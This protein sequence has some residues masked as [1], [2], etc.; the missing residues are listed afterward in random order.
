G[1]GGGILLPRKARCWDLARPCGGAGPRL[2][3]GSGPA[4]GGRK[5]AEARGVRSGA[6]APSSAAAGGRRTGRADDLCRPPPSSLP[7]L[8]RGGDG[9]SSSS[10]GR[11]DSAPSRS[12]HLLL[13]LWPRPGH[14]REELLWRRLLQSYSL[15]RR[16][17]RGI[18]GGCAHPRPNRPVAHLPRPLAA[19]ASSSTPHAAFLTRWHRRPGAGGRA[20]SGQQGAPHAGRA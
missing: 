12:C 14:A 9:T 20:G 8:R 4:E 2:C 18:G 3:S 6:G 7:Q 16:S 1:L 10:G 5:R 17:S 15:G 11:L 13:L 19:S